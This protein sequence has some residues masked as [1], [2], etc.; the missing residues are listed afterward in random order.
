MNIRDIFLALLVITVWGANFTV[1]KVGVDNI[2]PMLLAALRYVFTALPAVFFIPRPK[3][4]WKYKSNPPERI[5]LV[6]LLLADILY[7]RQISLAAAAKVVRIHFNLYNSQGCNC[8]L[9]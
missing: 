7:I 1:I 3:L 6:V 8:F 5:E 4:A 9:V 2:S